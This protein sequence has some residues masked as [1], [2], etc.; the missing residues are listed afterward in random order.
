MDLRN[1]SILLHYT[2]SQTRKP[3][4]CMSIDFLVQAVLP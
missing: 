1:I 2:V 4:S 3:V